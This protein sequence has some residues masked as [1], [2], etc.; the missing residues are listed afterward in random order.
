MKARSV[1]AA[2]PSEPT[3]AEIRR[4]IEFMLYVVD[5]YGDR[6]MPILESL[7]DDFEAMAQAEPPRVKAR[8]MLAAAMKDDT[9]RKLMGPERCEEIERRLAEPPA[10]RLRKMPEQPRANRCKLFDEPRR[11][12]PTSIYVVG[13]D[14]YVK[15]G[16]TE[17]DVQYRVAGLQT[18]CPEKLEIYAAF[19]GD[20]ILEKALHERFAHLRRNGEWF[21]REGDLAEWIEKGC[22]VDAA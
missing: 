10:P 20:L 2:S 7:V 11:Q 4:A 13:F 17:R 9:Q 19:R 15:I 22:P 18:G 3:A 21:L 12:L 1:R 5:T 14:R 16:I 8:R 6:Y